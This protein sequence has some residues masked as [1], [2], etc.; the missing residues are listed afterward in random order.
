VHCTQRS[1]IRRRHS[2]FDLDERNQAS[3]ITPALHNEIDVAMPTSEPPLN[4]PPAPLD[5]PLLCDPLAS[6]P[7]FLL[8]MRH[9]RNLGVHDARA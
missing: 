9:D 3:L 8:C 6:S 2:R 1:A 4:N 5:Q 7:K